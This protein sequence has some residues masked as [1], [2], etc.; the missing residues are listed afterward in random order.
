MYLGTYSR[1]RFFLF[2]CSRNASP[3]ISGPVRDV[4][5]QSGCV[6]PRPISPRDAVL[7]AE[8]RSHSTSSRRLVAEARSQSRK[9]ARGVFLQKRI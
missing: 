4:T 7:G 5:S 8:S 1:S 9:L 3:G 2:S 6:N